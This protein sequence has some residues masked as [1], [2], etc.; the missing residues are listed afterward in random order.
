MQANTNISRDTSIWHE[1]DRCEWFCSY[2]LHTHSATVKNTLS[3]VGAGQL[4]E[5]QRGAEVMGK[6]SF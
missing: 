3:W 4:V 6:A 2:F 5:R 1:E